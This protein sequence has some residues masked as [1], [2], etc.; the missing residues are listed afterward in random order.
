MVNKQVIHA[1]KNKCALN[2]EKPFVMRIIFSLLFCVLIQLSTAKSYAQ[3]TR[4]AMNASNVTV[5]EV[6]NSIE[7]NSDYVFLYSDRTLNTSR[8]VSVKT[9]TR[10]IRK[11]LDEIF[12]G[13]EINLQN[14][15]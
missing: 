5:G 3:H 1:L 8:I 9:K 11:I 13:T 15:K 10:D 2:F 7:H 12:H 4:K 6:L 14:S